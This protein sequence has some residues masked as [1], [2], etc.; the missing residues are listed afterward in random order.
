MSAIINE[1]IEKECSEDPDTV[2]W[3]RVRRRVL[4]LKAFTRTLSKRPHSPSRC[5]DILPPPPAAGHRRLL[6]D[7][8]RAAARGLARV[9]VRSGASFGPPSALILCADFRAAHHM[10]GRPARPQALRPFLLYSFE[11]PQYSR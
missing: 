7:G 11:E 6:S 9:A 8:E 5:T 1:F 3:A 4:P 10:R 2:D